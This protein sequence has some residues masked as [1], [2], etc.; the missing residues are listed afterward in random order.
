MVNEVRFGYNRM[1]IGQTNV[2]ANVKNPVNV[3]GSVPGL[4]VVNIC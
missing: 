3:G 1:S 4:P 2:D